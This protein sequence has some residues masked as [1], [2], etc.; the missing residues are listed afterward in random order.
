MATLGPAAGILLRDQARAN[1]QLKLTREV[2]Q[3]EWCTSRVSFSCQ[4]CAT[5]SP[6]ST[7]RSWRAHRA[8]AGRSSPV[9]TARVARSARA[10][11]AGAAVGEAR[12]AVEERELLESAAQFRRALPHVRPGRPLKVLLLPT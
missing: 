2:H 4:C 1:W 3:Y 6:T 7:P 11:R 8:H 9:P 5:T 12:S 10:T